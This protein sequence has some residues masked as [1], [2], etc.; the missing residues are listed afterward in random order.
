[1]DATKFTEWQR[2]LDRA[3]KL[4]TALVSEEVLFIRVEA[5][6]ATYDLHIFLRFD[7]ERRLLNGSLE[8]HEIPAAWNAAFEELFGKVP[9]NDAQGCL[10]DIHWSMGGLGYFPTYTLG[11]LNSAQLF[12]SAKRQRGIGSAI[13][14]AEHQP[15]LRWLREN[16]HSVGA[17]RSPKEII[18]NATGSPTDPA[19][20]LNHLRKR[21]TH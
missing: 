1:M 12:Q 4:P 2:E 3:T 21:F 5:D 15:L 8:P 11:N 10:Q 20:Y 6:E 9:P 17:S 13:R 7:I 14:R 19:P 16:V 18:A